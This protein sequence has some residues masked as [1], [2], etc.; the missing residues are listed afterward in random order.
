MSTSFPQA[1]SASAG[2]GNLFA[3]PRLKYVQDRSKNGPA[4][5]VQ[6]ARGVD[7]HELLDEITEDNHK[8]DH[9][10]HNVP[11]G[12]P[13]QRR[14]ASPTSGIRAERDMY[15]ERCNQLLY[16]VRSLQMAYKEVDK[17]FSSLKDSSKFF[18]LFL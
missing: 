11:G 10:R 7:I 8:H 2:G 13:S 4:E 15:A 6:G 3:S 5:P 18:E 16:Q 14:T 12:S 1:P 9:G 17:L